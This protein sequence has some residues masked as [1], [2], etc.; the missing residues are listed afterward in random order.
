MQQYYDVIILGESL[1]S[2]IAAV[3]LARGGCRVLTLREAEPSFP[4]WL[5][6]SLHLERLLEK[7]D[8]RACFTPA[9]PFQVLTG[10]SRL[11]FNGPNTLEE[12]LRRELGGAFSQ[13][14]EA[15]QRLQ[16]LGTHL[17]DVLWES[18]GPPLLGLSSRLRFA[19][20]RLR[21]QL[22]LRQLQRPFQVDLETL[23]PGPGRR[24]LE[25]LFSGLAL[26]PAAS[27]SL[28]E[29]ALLWNGAGKN[30]GISRSA[31]D[32]LL[33]RRY[34]QFHGEEG[35]LSH[36][37]SMNAR[38]KGTPVATL[39]DGTE[40]GARYCLIGSSSCSAPLP[41]A[42]DSQ[43]N[44]PSA[45][46]PLQFVTS[47]LGDKVS[48]LLAPFVLLEGEWPLRIRFVPE[49]HDMV[50]IID[51]FAEDGPAAEIEKSLQ[52]RLRELL[53]FVD[54]NLE[55]ASHETHSAETPSGCQPPF[56][57]VFPGAHTSLK[58]KG[59]FF[60]CQ[61]TRVFPS[62]GATGEVLVGTTIGRHL[63]KQL[64]KPVEI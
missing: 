48:P 54:F 61:G 4:A 47:S 10:E 40:W 63:L 1:A 17:E 16:L 56:G 13:A 32:E 19:G 58:A 51:C 44:P 53:P 35:D 8:G 37:Q 50:A 21:R 41:K 2:R 59:N 64:K 62:L 26:R 45:P 57:Q 15:L 9:R 7:L 23:E 11:D 34:T 12:E 30:I 33:R 6:P 29:V 55:R 31:L 25:T 27:L 3:L 22:P 42:L 24:V 49:N 28:A 60:C 18:G 43:A 39:K 14:F 38:D 36:L 46:V 52:V 20:K 5:W